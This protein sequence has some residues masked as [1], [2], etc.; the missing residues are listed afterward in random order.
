MRKIG[1]S[2]S[3]KFA[4]IQRKST[5][6][7]EPMFS[8]EPTRRILGLALRTDNTRGFVDIGA[9]WARFFAEGWLA[10]IPGKQ[11]DTV[12]AV[13]GLFENLEVVHAGRIADLRYTLVIG[14]EVA[15]GVE[16]TPGLIGIDLPAQRTAV[17]NV[18]SGQPQDVGARWQEIWALRDLPRA[19][20]ADAERYTADGRIDIL[21]GLQ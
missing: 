12:W 4:A 8:T 19:F 10:K 6:M 14:A 20:V 13:Y 2:G 5:P 15:P 18:Q 9:H 3:G 1:Q 11:S 16:A 21:V 17:F 7:N